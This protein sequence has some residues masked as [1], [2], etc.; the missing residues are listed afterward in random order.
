MTANLSVGSTAN[1]ATDGDTDDDYDLSI[2]GSTITQV[3]L[4]Y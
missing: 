3:R 2:G 4:H 1:Q